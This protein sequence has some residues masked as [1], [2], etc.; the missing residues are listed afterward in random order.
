MPDSF[1]VIYYSVQ[2]VTKIVQRIFSER[3]IQ[4]FLHT[5]LIIINI[6]IYSFDIGMTNLIYVEIIRFAG[7]MLK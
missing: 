2:A 6:Y 5:T 4:K 3:F 7:D 1:P